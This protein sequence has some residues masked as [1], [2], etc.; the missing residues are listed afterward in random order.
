MRPFGL[1]A[2]DLDVAFGR[3]PEQAAT[4]LLARCTG[5]DEAT[6]HGWTLARRLQALLAVRLADDPKAQ[7]DAA[8]RCHACGEAF[9]FSLPL[10][11]CLAEVD[12]SPLEW[13]AP[14]GRRLV[15][16]LPRAADLEAWRG[17]DEAAIAARMAGTEVPAPWQAPLAAAL[18]ERDPLSALAVEAACPACG[19]VHD[20]EVDL[21]SLLLAHFGA[22]QRRLLDE[23][24]TLARAF[25]WSEAQI[26]ALPAWRRAHYLAGIEGGLA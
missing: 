15:L 1:A 20:V 6:V 4:A 9:E 12:D 18:A 16:Q 14:D 13:T 19:H 2:A 10:A 17:L 11:P 26:L 24:A 3:A 25:H 5:H 7:A 21:Q 8:V 23:V 22:R